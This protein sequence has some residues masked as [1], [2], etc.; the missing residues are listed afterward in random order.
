MAQFRSDLEAFVSREV[1]ESCVERGVFERPPLRNICYSAFCDPSGGSSDSFTLCIAHNETAKQV[2]VIDCLRERRPPFSPEAVC[3]EFTAVLKSYGLAKVTADRFGGEWV[4][5][6]FGKFGV[7]VEP[8]AKP[9][10]DLYQDTLALLN[11]TR[12]SL[13]DDQRAFNQLISLERRTAR[14][15]RDVIDH[16]PNQH[17]DLINSVA[18]VASQLIV[19]GTYNLDALADLDDADPYGIEHYREARLRNYLASGGMIR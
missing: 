6:Q 11:S 10:S 1:A 15:G 2:V 12:I 7:I 14:S 18:G 16:P 19:K 9:K 8:A 3:S 17:D 13:L 4:R 5:E